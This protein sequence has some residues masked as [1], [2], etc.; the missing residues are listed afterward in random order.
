[1]TVD[2]TQAEKQETSGHSPLDGLGWSSEMI[3]G[4]YEYSYFECKIRTMNTKHAKVTYY[5]FSL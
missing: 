3:N 5:T 4:T 2:A 1:L